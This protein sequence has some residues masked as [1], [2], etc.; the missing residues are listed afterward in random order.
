LMDGGYAEEFARLAVELHEQSGVPET[1]DA[2]LTYAL[3]A[4]GADSGSVM[5]LR[6]GGRA[7]EVAG[8]TDAAAERADHLQLETGEGP[9]LDAARDDAYSTV[10]TDTRVDERF[11]TWGKR[12]ASD[13]G[14]LSVLSVQLGTPSDRVGALNLY[15]VEPGR[16]DADD[17]AVAHVLVRHAAVALARTDREAH[18]WLAIDARNLIGQAQG[19][20]MERFDLDADRAF[21]VLRRYSQDNNLKLRE[22]AQRLV[23]TRRLPDTAGPGHDG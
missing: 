19:I 23:D 3:G 21:S 5:L 4:V 6:K 9:C 18:L 12:V 13:V 14:I 8:S 16:F 2:V 7:I 1:V 22:V 11:P 15:S 10:I 17:R 20:L